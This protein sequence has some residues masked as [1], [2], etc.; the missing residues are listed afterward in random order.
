MGLGNLPAQ[1]Q[2]DPG[3][4]GL[5]GEEGYEEVS[6]AGQAGAVVH[7]PDLQM[8]LVPDPGD[9]NRARSVHHRIGSVLDQIDEQL[10][11]L[12][13]IGLDGEVR[14]WDYSSGEPGFEA[15]KVS[16]NS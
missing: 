7:H 9:G 14:A 6:G 5:G 15:A 3:T 11:Q 13:A 4:V 1:S 8:L 16:S 2:S 10:V 12:I